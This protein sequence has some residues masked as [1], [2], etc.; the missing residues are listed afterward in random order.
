MSKPASICQAALRVLETADARHKATAARE[1]AHDWRQGKFAGKTKA[2]PVDR[3]ARPEKPELLLPRDMPKRGKGG[4][5]ENRIA[6][7]HAIAHIELNAIDLAWDMV[8]RF[9]HDMPDDFI[10]DWV[11]VGDDE[12]RHFIMIEERLTEL[13][14]GYGALPA[15]D[16]LWQAAFDTRNDLAAR[17]A[18]VP[19]VLEA[20]GLDVTP[21]MIKR[22]ENFGDTKSAEALQV[23]YDE[24]I[25]HVRKGQKWF[26]WLC[27]K[28]GW[29]GQEKYQDLVRQH[30]SGKL[31]PPFNVS[32]RAAAGLDEAYYLPLS[33]T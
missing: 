3:P 18:I 25:D 12:A 29:D 2:L 15:H 11:G 31:K 1:L 5:L 28:S 8:A 20:R 13:G 19:M 24:E 10:D 16:G 33:D 6:L 7:M 9:G 4:N 26:S 27:E 23:I 21:G 14:A 32:A 30:F 17:L 22:L